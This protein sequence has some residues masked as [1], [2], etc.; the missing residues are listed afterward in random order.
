[1]STASDRTLKAR[2]TPHKPRCRCRP[3][4]GRRRRENV[5][6]V[7]SAAPEQGESQAFG[8]TP[9]AR[10][11]YRPLESAALA[12]RVE[13]PSARSADSGAR[14]ISDES[15]A[16]PHPTPTRAGMSLSLPDAVE[17]SA[18]TPPMEQPAPAR[19]GPPAHPVPAPEDDGPSLPDYC[20]TCGRALP[21]G[22]ISHHRL[23]VPACANARVSKTPPSRRTT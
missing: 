23:L 5:A 10:P 11:P 21:P 14:I 13:E 1:M 3:C 9:W 15:V 2:Q 18:A 8:K 6:L 16:G 17:P 7:P 12:A 22:G 4:I 20:Q 19:M